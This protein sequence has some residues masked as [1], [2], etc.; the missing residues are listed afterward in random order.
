MRVESFSLKIN[1]P[2]ISE[3]KRYM[4]AGGDNSEALNIAVREQIEKI[5]SVATPRVCYA[6]LPI[7]FCGDK[8]KIGDLDMQSES[9]KKRL[10][11]CELA[12][13][14]AATVGYDV[15][16][17]IRAESVKSALLG[18]AADAVGSAAIEETCDALCEMLSAN[19][20]NAGY[21]TKARFSCGYGDL[22]IEHQGKILDMLD[23]KKNIGVTL[24][25]GG[26]MTP[27]KT[28]TAIAGIKKEDFQ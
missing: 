18:F 13:V 23:A 9:L 8:I 7:S 2:N 16:R 20:K 5:C 17:A 10:I 26:M 21:S 6:R 22:S 4:R 25:L 1:P 27:M 28:V 15:D 14:F 19:E 24:T 12:Y 3:V 11:G